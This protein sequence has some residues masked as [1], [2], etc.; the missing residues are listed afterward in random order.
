M[1]QIFSKISFRIHNGCWNHMKVVLFG[2]YSISSYQKHVHDICVDKSYET[3]IYKK[4]HPWPC[5]KDVEESNVI[6]Y[7]A[8]DDLERAVHKIQVAMS[9]QTF[10]KPGYMCKVFSDRSFMKKAFFEGGAQNL[11]NLQSWS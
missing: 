5:I 2:H 8:V 10:A 7:G 3:T 1:K 11:I 4:R 9:R 6:L